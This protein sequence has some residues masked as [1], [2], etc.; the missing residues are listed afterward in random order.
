MHRL[1]IPAIRLQIPATRL[2]IS[3]ITTTD[4]SYYDYKFRLL[5][6]GKAPSDSLE[7]T[8]YGPI[9]TTNSGYTHQ[10]PA[11]AEKSCLLQPFYRLQIPAMAPLVA[12]FRCLAKV[13]FGNP[14]PRYCVFRVSTTNSGY[15][16]R[17]MRLQIP[18][19]AL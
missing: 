11:A 6:T 8:L 3:A 19:V 4:F 7:S 18:G 17:G 12:F 16:V 5:S 13:T 10:A 1:R 9:T 15:V 2:Q 14:F